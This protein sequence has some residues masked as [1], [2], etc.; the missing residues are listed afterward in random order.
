MKEIVIISGKGGTGKSSLAASFAALAGNAVL[1]DCDVDAADLHLLTNA[2]ILRREEYFEGHEAVIRQDDCIMCGACQ[3]SCR[4]GAVEKLNYDDRFTGGAAAICKNCSGGCVRSCPVK[5]ADMLQAIKDTCGITEQYKYMINPALCEGC[6]V[7]VE[8]CPVNAIDFSQRRKGE[9]FISSTKYGEL[10][11]ARQIPGSGHS[12]R[13]AVKVRKEAQ[14]LAAEKEPE[15]VI[16]DGPPGS[17]SAVAAVINGATLVLVLVEPTSTGMHEMMR[18]IE[19]TRRYEIPVMIC[20]NKWDV[21]PDMT[22]RIEAEALKARARIAGRIRYD[23][24][25]ASQL[26]PGKTIVDISCAAKEDI[27]HIWNNLSDIIQKHLI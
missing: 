26:T 8:Q 23:R 9:W 12:D 4:F 14:K 1:A 25:I 27:Q 22:T 20:V 13:L 21:N 10:V 24:K 16:T 3:E 11:H 18:V 7:C 6:G 19:L 17:G 5:Y 2:S 15:L